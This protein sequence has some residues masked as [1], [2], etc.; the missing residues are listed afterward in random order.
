LHG[1]DRGSQFSHNVAALVRRRGMTCEAIE[2]C[3]VAESKA[4]PK[5]KPVIAVAAMGATLMLPVIAEVG[6]LEM[7]IFARMA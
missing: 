7:P 6:T 5:P 1:E 2:N 3:L 4:K